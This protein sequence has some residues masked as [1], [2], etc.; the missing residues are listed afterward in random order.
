M[1]PSPD[2]L[3]VLPRAICEQDL[4][5]CLRI[6]PFRL[7]DGLVGR[8]RALA[9][10]KNLIRSRFCHSV[11]I[12]ASRPVAGH[13]I[14]GFGID[15]FVSRSFAEKEISQ[16]APGLNDRI[17]ASLSSPHPVVL[18]ESEIRAANTQ[19]GLD[20]A[21]L[22]GCWREDLPGPEAVSEVCTALATCFMELH[23]GYRIHQLLTEVIGEEQRRYF[24]ATHAWRIVKAFDSPGGR[25]RCCAVLTRTDALS[26][27][28]SLVN[29]LFHHREPNLGLRDAD[30]QLLL[31]ALGGLT[32]EELAGKLGLTVAAVKKRWIS[33]FERTIDSHPDRFP[34][35]SPHDQPKRGPQKRHHI[36][37]YV[38]LHPEELRPTE[39]LREV[40]APAD[41]VARS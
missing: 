3:G 8:D 5:D 29:G 30:Q 40:S 31:A 36:L 14:V 41:L 19:G 6:D 21:I 12:E 26:V 39:N 27:A 18:T 22:Y 25:P 23:R 34:A 9:S 10:W 35:L 37:A 4:R 7:G 2:V 20:V 32:D 28:G 16:P 13:R 38:R 17:L 24:E 1:A 15:V 11:V 33:L